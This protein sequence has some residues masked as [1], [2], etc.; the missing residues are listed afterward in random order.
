M[1]KE[2]FK[3]SVLKTLC[4][5]QVF[6][7]PLTIHEL[8]KYLISDK[9]ISYQ[10]FLLRFY[11]TRQDFEQIG[12]YV[13]LFGDKHLVTQRHSRAYESKRK[14]AKAH[15]IS[16]FLSVIP[17][18][19]LIAVSGSLSMFN[20]KKTDDIDLFFITSKNSLWISRFLV[21]LILFFLG[22]K[23]GRKEKYAKDKVC[24][25]M[26]ISED[27][28]TISKKTMYTAHEVAQM[29]VIFSR[30]DVVLDFFTANKWVLKFLPNVFVLGKKH[31][32]EKSIH[33]GFLL[34]AIEKFFYFVQLQ[35]MKKRITHETIKKDV[36]AFHPIQNDKII[37]MLYTLKV[38]TQISII[39]DKNR[40]KSNHSTT[41]VN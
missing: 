39:Q 25:N 38:N 30:E 7:Y 4:Y 31:K 17:T 19:K 28:L 6:S 14:M 24:P 35:Y 32:K 27:R 8:W 5:S 13:V 40:H 20:A 1:K 26:F 9:K 3:Y 29:K 10:E 22:E 21:N 37:Q 41:V 36:A 16:Q 2:T 34:Q 18:I 33:S 11:K 15:W 23:R 12:E